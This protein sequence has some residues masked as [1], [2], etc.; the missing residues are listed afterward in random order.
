ML[1]PSVLDRGMRGRITSERTNGIAGL[2]L[3]GPWVGTLVPARA[4]PIHAAVGEV[5]SASSAQIAE[6]KSTNC[7]SQPRSAQWG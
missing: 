5:H 6:L 2:Q 1:V 7:C 4:I 3:E